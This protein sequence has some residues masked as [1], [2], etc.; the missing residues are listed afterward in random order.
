MIRL[1]K[2]YAISIEYTYAIVK[3]AQ[4]R[5]GDFTPQPIC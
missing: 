3:W 5:G 4:Q 2:N 1:R